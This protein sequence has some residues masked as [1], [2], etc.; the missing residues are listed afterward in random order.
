MKDIDLS[1]MI[2]KTKLIFE[3][4]EKKYKIFLSQDKLELLDNLI[5]SNLFKISEDSNLPFIYLLGDTYYL[6]STLSQ[7]INTLN[8]NDLISNYL[9]NNDINNIYLELTTFLCLSLLCSDL[10]PLKI[11]L[12]ER[13][14]REISKEYNIKTSQISNYKEY[15]VSSIIYDVLLKDLPINIIFLDSEIEIF[16]YLTIEKGIEV[17]KLYYKISSLMKEKYNNFNK[18]YSL[19]NMIDYYNNIN[20][21]DVLDIIYNYVN[22]KIR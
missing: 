20:Y 11:G 5:Y 21:D 2:N 3:I 8:G 15:E 1:S 16:H 6:N 9:I 10:N 18:D 4:L 12:I 7:E 19:K 13:E 22:K 14:V 17:A